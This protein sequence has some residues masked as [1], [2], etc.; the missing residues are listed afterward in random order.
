MGG[1]LIIRIGS[2]QFSMR[3]QSPCVIFDTLNSLAPSC[4]HIT[5][6]LIDDRFTTT[7][8]I[9]FLSTYPSLVAKD[10]CTQRLETC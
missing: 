2:E 9:S 7:M 1:V 5:Q 6:R 8:L 3:S 10:I 4:N